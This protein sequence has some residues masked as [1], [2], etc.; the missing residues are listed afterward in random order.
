MVSRE[1]LIHRDFGE[2][3][4]LKI[5]D[6]RGERL[7]LR[8]LAEHL[9]LRRALMIVLPTFGKQRSLIASQLGFSSEDAGGLRVIA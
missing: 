4:E 5:L 7:K 8:A 1:D 3:G 6:V 2:R 9:D